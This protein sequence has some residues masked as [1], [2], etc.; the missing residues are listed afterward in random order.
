MNECRKVI[1]N[2]YRVLITTLTKK[3]AE[4]VTEYFNE[5]GLS[6][7]YLHSDIDTIERMEIIKDLRT[8]AF[9]ILIGINLLR[10][11]LDIPECGLVAILDG[12]KE[13]FLRSRVSLIQTIG[14]AARNKE[15]KVIIYADILTNAIKEA[16]N[17]TD[18]RRK[19]QEQ[20][21]IKNNIIP[22]STKR[23]ILDIGIYG[24]SKINNA[25]ESSKITKGNNLQNHLKN[26]KEDMIKEA[27]NLNFEQ[28]AILR[29]EIK[30]LEENELGIK[31][32]E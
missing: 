18:R 4:K 23:K 3:H 22:K 16:K 5:N 1:D 15:S 17:E 27:E 26:L 10:E 13:G 9:D 20:Y 29:D 7:K 19:K 32:D 25:K 6:S 12:D 24:L 14:R 30:K 31:E 11:G 21:N 8:G 28:A 2:N